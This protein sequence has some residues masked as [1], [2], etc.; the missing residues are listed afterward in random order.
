MCQTAP[1]R[2]CGGCAHQSLAHTEQLEVILTW[3]G[4]YRDH[5]GGSPSEAREWHKSNIVRDLLR[6]QYVLE[7]VVAMPLDDA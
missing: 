7:L 3:Q 2:D 6:Y 1:R 4:R 5:E